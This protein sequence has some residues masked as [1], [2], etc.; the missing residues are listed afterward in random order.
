[1]LVPVADHVLDCVRPVSHGALHPTRHA[2]GPASGATIRRNCERGRHRA[3]LSVIE[4]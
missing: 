2:A 3:K 1:M 4:L